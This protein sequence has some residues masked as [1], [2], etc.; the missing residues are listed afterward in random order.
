M[1]IE[2]N[3]S[4]AGLS[5]EKLWNL[6]NANTETQGTAERDFVYLLTVPISRDRSSGVWGYES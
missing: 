1:Q 2:G 6:K 3:S 5:V 4:Y